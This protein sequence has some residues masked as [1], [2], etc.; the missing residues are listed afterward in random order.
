MRKY[1]ST[2]LVASVLIASCSKEAEVIREKIVSQS[3]PILSGQGQPDNG[4]GEDGD[5]YLD[6]T[7][8]KLYGPKTQGAWGEPSLDLKGLPGKDGKDGK[9][10][11]NGQ[12]GQPGR[13]GQNGT[14]G[15]SPRIG[16]NGNWWVGNTDLGVKAQG[17]PG[18]KGQDGQPGRDGQNGTTPRIGDNGNWWIGNEDTGKPARGTQGQK[19]QDGQPG[20][21]GQNGAAPRI[22]DNGNWWVGNEDTGKPARGAQGERGIPGTNGRDGNNGFTPYIGPNGN[23]WVDNRDTGKPARG[24]QGTP[25]QNG[26][27]GQNGAAGSKILAEDRAPQATDG[28]KGDYFIDKAAKI[29]YGPK[30][31]AGWPTTGI[32]LG[33]NQILSADYQLSEDGKTLVKWLNPK[34][35]HIDM[36]AD[37]RLR[38][39]TKIG[40]AAFDKQANNINYQLTTIIVGDKVT[41]IG[42]S[43]FRMCDRLKSVELPEGITRIENGTF[44][45]CVR[46]QIIEIPESVTSIGD[47]AFSTCVKLYTVIL[48]ERV[49]SL[50][51]AAFGNCASLHSIII[52]NKT[53]FAIGN[54]VFV[55]TPIQNIYVF[56]E[57]VD[58]YKNIA[59]PL[60]KDKIKALDFP[61]DQF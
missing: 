34:T 26:T 17:A 14:N 27:N 1:L 35:R 2:L 32:Y 55:Q 30:T 47:G 53:A 59:A 44:E 7:N 8:A 51:N 39:V 38:E 13:D 24:E 19:G 52:R 23:W 21:D 10:G 48:P 4:K 25:G 31:D 29:F 42:N 60:Y 58:D 40:S 16:E 22:G 15:E 18:Q 46:L 57:K 43:A 3:R 5:Y 41:E 28:V 20:R 61:H 6:L 36:N 37:P 50:G 45:G 9:D 49:N 33:T 12:D 11:Q 54:S 56:S